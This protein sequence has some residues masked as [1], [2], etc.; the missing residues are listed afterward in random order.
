MDIEFQK[1][2][3]KKPLDA[4]PPE[5]L[6]I[7]DLLSGRNFIKDQDDIQIYGSYTW[8]SQPYPSDVDMMQEVKKCCTNEKVYIKMEDIINSVVKDVN[9]INTIYLTEAKIGIDNRYFDLINKEGFIDHDILEKALEFKNNKLLTDEEYGIIKDNYPIKNYANDYNI[10]TIL[11]NRWV[12]RWGINDLKKGYLIANGKKFNI[13][14]EITDPNS[15]I[16][17]DIV[18]PLS[19]KYMEITNFYVLVD[20]YGDVL[21]SDEDY[22]K[23]LKDQ[24]SDFLVNP[25]ELKAYKMAKRMWALTRTFYKNT[26]N[27]IYASRLHTLTTLLQDPVGILYQ[28]KSEIE[29]ILTISQQK[30]SSDTKTLIFEQIGEW[31]NRISYVK[32]NS[33]LE[34]EIFKLIN[35]ILEKLNTKNKIDVETLEKLLDLIYGYVNNYA[36]KYLKRVNLFP[37]PI[38]YLNDVFIKY[39]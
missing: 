39:L 27:N 21:N 29:A 10:Y 32:L 25:K 26:R 3:K 2:T 23:Q 14:N 38:E 12:L 24:I 4:Y 16:K 36:L 1:L 13:D 17:I 18:A 11:R 8:L 15:P 35:D 20:K 7:I 34:N 6:Y 37:V 30:L 31:K 9:R 28:I 5:L 22:E 19:G 33:V